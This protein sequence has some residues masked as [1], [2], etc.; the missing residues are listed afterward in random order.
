MKFKNLK[1]EQV[2]LA[3]F[4]YNK[5]SLR[6]AL[7][8]LQRLGT[9]AMEFYTADPHFCLEDCTLD[10][11]KHVKRM[12]D[13]RELRVI[14]VCPENCTYPMNL[15]SKN[16]NTRKRTFDNYVNAIHVAS[17]WECPHVLIFPGRA[18]YDES[19]EEAW[20]YGVDAMA[21][22]ADIAQENGVKI[23]LESTSKGSTVIVG[24]KK[25]IQMMKEINSP[26]LTGMLDLMC[27]EITK[28]DIREA[29]KLLG[30]ERVRHIHFS[31]AEQ[32][33]P[34]RWEH[35]VPGDGTLPVEDML[36]ALDEN[37]YKDYFGCEVFAPYL[38]EP[39]K[40]MRRMRDW[41]A[42]RFCG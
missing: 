8:S 3:N 27:L 25:T 29:I 24:V 5:Y 11:M 19:M 4:V 37:G 33:N 15:A 10:D 40:A 2:A 22:L 39:E 12:L 30:I 35:R 16:I 9:H 23:V 17:E 28:D 14:N 13:E 31:D 41:C 34:G 38:G 32:V 7:D 26:A 42:E 36:Q 6:Y 1:M 20:Q 21:A 18:L